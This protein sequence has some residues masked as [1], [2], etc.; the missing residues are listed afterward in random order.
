MGLIWCQ[1]KALGCPQFVRWGFASSRA[2]ARQFVRHN[3]VFVNGHKA[4]IP[5]MVL[6]PGDIVSVRDRPKSAQLATAAF[7]SISQRQ[8]P[9]W[10]K[11]DGKAL[12]G[13]VL[14]IPTMDEIA[15]AVQVQLVVE[16]YS[17]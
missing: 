9:T 10:L 17:R 12:T 6:K 16:L 5:S 15:P 13:E 4:N 2:Y 8:M 7:E 14:S 3:H 11:V 1:S